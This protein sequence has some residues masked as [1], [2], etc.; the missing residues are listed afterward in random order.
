MVMIERYGTVPS[1]ESRDYLLYVI[2]VYMRRVLFHS[3]KTR[4]ICDEDQIDFPELNCLYNISTLG[5]R[6]RD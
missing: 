2:Y 5:R 4:S 1:N 6:R 3:H